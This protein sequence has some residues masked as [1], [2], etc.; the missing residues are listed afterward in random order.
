MSMPRQSVS[1]TD[2]R[3]SSAYDCGNHAATRA[4]A[5]TYPVSP[6]PVFQSARSENAQCA[7]QSPQKRCGERAGK[8]KRKG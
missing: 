7:G 1:A 6:P 5:G 2:T 8:E 4:P 3:S